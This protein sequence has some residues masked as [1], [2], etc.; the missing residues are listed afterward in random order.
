MSEYEIEIPEGLPAEMKALM[1]HIVTIRFPEMPEKPEIGEWYR[2]SPEGC[3]TSKGTPWHGTFRK[4][5]ENRLMIQFGG[6]GCSWNEYTAARPTKLVPGDEP[7]FYFA[8]TSWAADAQVHQGICLPGENNPF[9]DWSVLALPYSSGDFHCGTGNFPYTGLDGD[10]TILYHHGYTNYRAAMESVI[11]VV[12]DPEKI[13]VC[14]ESAGGFGTALLTDDVMGLYPKCEDVTCCV[15]SSVAIKSD[16]Q[17]V[18]RL[19]WEAPQQIVEC[20]NTDN[21][22]LDMLN[23]LHVKQKSKVK[24]LFVCS[25][26]DMALAALQ[27]YFDREK[28][29]STKETA[30]RIQ[31]VIKEFCEQLQQMVPDCGIYIFDKVAQDE[32][33]EHLTIHTILMEAPVYEPMNDSISVMDWLWEAVNGN[34]DK[35]GLELL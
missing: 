15:D 31:L 35:V 24:I 3:V 14:G 20:L 25:K 7:D 26:R 17:K 2:I 30:D 27:S 9:S 28:M 6:G 19:V 11:R 23:H 5:K 1:E 4:G 29:E 18:A 10:E 16:W 32:N 22:T 12:P 21:I 8:D 33:G 34:I 13:L